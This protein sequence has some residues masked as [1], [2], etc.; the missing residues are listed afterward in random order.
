MVLL[1]VLCTGIVMSKKLKALASAARAARN[2]DDI[3]SLKGLTNK[4]FV[5]GT[6]VN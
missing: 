6:F 1:A 3:D 4:A 5:K 2:A